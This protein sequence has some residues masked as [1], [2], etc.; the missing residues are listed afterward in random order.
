MLC[1]EQESEYVMDGD[2][3]ERKLWA[4]YAEYAITAAHELAR[5]RPCLALVLNE[6][7]KR[8]MLLAT[9]DK[10]VKKEKGN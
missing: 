5:R 2:D 6:E 1:F 9:K 4:E 10:K 3:E 7:A 8:S